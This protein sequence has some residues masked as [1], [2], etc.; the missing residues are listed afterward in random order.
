MI[1][2]ERKGIGMKNII[3][4]VTR[5]DYSDYTICAIFDNKEMAEAYKDV[6]DT[7]SFNDIEEY[8]LNPTIR[9]NPTGLKRYSVSL[10]NDGK[11]QWCELQGALFDKPVEPLKFRFYER[12]YHE[13]CSFTCRFYVC[14][15]DR[16]HAIKLAG[17]KRQELQRY[18]LWL[19]TYENTL[20]ACA[21]FKL[22][23]VG[24]E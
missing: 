20:A 22:F 17:E 24:K 18:G 4:V 14:A 12:T 21:K 16:E 6:E 11:L 23:S 5:G 1:K 13:N 7:G 9:Q 8:E 10:G 2:K 19:D 3:Y 15:K